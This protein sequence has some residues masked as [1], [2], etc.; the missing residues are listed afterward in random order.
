MKAAAFLLLAGLRLGAQ[1]TTCTPA[2]SSV[3]CT[4]SKPAPAPSGAAGVLGAIFQ[5][6]AVDRANQD[7]RDAAIANRLADSIRLATTFARAEQKTKSQLDLFI[8]RASLIIQRGL[9]SL[10]LDG[11][12]KI[13]NAYWREATDAAVTLFSLE[14]MASNQQIADAVEPVV[15]SYHKRLASFDE[16]AIAII[17]AAADS[18]GIRPTDERRRF[19]L[20]AATP[21]LPLRDDDWMTNDAK[22]RDAIQP[23]IDSVRANRAAREAKAYLDSA[24]KVGTKKPPVKKKPPSGARFLR[25]NDR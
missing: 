8:P 23:A 17:T 3:V 9:D 5:G 15:S 25:L 22:L 24:A 18:L 21:L 13:S 2:G 1:T 14:P 4:T 12:G 20:S 7:A 16:R 19:R 6:M 11:S 10:W